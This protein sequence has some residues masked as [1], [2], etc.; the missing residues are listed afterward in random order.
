MMSSRNC[1]QRSRTR[2]LKVM[3]ITA[4]N[5]SAPQVNGILTV[6]GLESI[7]RVHQ[8]AVSMDGRREA[9]RLGRERRI[10]TR[11]RLDVIILRKRR[12]SPYATQEQMMLAMV[13]PKAAVVEKWSDIPTAEAKAGFTCRVVHHFEIQTSKTSVR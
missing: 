7:C 10:Q 9:I 12:D 8:A 3:Q 13:T 5:Q 2:L 11:G 4:Q 1:L 6:G